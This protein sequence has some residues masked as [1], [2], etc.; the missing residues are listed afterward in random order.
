MHDHHEPKQSETLQ[1]ISKSVAA[2]KKKVRI[3]EEEELVWFSRRT[4]KATVDIDTAM[5]FSLP[6]PSQAVNLSPAKAEKKAVVR[7]K[8]VVKRNKESEKRRRHDA[9][10]AKQTAPIRKPLEPLPS[11]DEDELSNDSLQNIVP[12][13]SA[14]A[15]TNNSHGVPKPSKRPKAV[16]L[17]KSTIKASR[18]K[19]IEAQNVS[20]QTKKREEAIP[21]STEH[22][23]SHQSEPYPVPE[24]SKTKNI[25]PKSTKTKVIKSRRV[26]KPT[27]T[28]AARDG[29][30][31]VDRALISPRE[32]TNGTTPEELPCEDSRPSKKRRVVGTETR[33][34]TSN[35]HEAH[36]PE[37]LPDAQAAKKTRVARKA[38]KET[39]AANP[40]ADP[41]RT[42]SP[43]RRLPLKERNS[44]STSLKALVDEDEHCLPPKKK[45]TSTV[46]RIGKDDPVAKSVCLVGGGMATIGQTSID[47]KVVKSSTRG[48]GRA[49]S[50]DASFTGDQ[51][52]HLKAKKASPLG[53][54]DTSDTDQILFD[55]A[56][57]PKSTKR[58]PNPS[59]RKF[60]DDSEIDLDQ[61]LDGIAA[62]ANSGSTAMSATEKPARTAK[63]RTRI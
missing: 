46:S 30:A 6:E 48:Q 11:D 5:P 45:D 63:K 1:V 19:V 22:P 15:E 31:L 18:K 59:K 14:T 47:E 55:T 33:M 21:W 41:G 29:E 37:R 8:R 60:R 2:K 32:E 23:L 28:K 20:D 13:R 36:E 25:R 27:P 9:S 7:K 38:A 35:Q 40:R 52:T 62:I 58:A 3:E 56:A 42:S 26:T 53:T 43:A 24:A 39:V 51:T 50:G 10:E 54:T 44:N 16:P 49:R 57:P 12:H 17:K 34:Q 61:M 4:K